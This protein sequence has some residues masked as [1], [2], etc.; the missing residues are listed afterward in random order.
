MD[1][2]CN[3]MSEHKFDI[4]VGSSMGGA[5]IVE[6]LARQ[7]QLFQ[8]PVLLLAPAQKTVR[9]KFSVS[10]EGSF[11]PQSGLMSVSTM[12]SE[13]NRYRK[14]C[15]TGL[16]KLVIVHGAKDT[17]VSIDDSKEF[18][19]NVVG[20]ELIEVGGNLSTSLR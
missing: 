11:D 7:G 4:V 18:A 20:A 17:V 14:E 1:I 13:I 9:K 5:T 16:Q 6:A 10:D 3:V 15:P 8:C 2:L 19:S 12:Y